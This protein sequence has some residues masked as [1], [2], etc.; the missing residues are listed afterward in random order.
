MMPFSF[1]TFSRPPTPAILLLTR[2]MMMMARAAPHADHA[3]ADVC[4]TPLPERR[5][6]ARDAAFTRQIA[7]RHATADY[8]LRWHAD[9]LPV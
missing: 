8:T 3:A 5:A 2:A 1:Y 7:W 9:T 4:F 6:A